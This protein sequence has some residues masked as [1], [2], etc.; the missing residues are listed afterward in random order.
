MPAIT[1][2]CLCGAVRYSSS[3]QPTLTA[4]CHCR[5]CQKTG[6]GGYSVNVAVHLVRL[7]AALGQATRGRD[8]RLK[9]PIIE[10][11]AP[12]YLLAVLTMRSV[13]CEFAQ[14]EHAKRL[15]DGP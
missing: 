14:P 13:W 5:S 11:I 4:F 1:G 2:S 12:M 6:G 7:R 15:R 10:L 8:V 9:E 3:A